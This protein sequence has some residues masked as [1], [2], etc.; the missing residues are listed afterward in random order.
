MARNKKGLKKIPMKRIYLYFSKPEELELLE[1]AKKLAKA[2]DRP[3]GRFIK[4]ALRLF[5][6]TIKKVD[7]YD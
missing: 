7:S 3:L 5:I 1:E 2:S 6:G 4:R